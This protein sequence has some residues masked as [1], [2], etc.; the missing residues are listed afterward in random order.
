MV[1]PATGVTINTVADASVEDAIA[2]IDA[3]ARAAPT[4]ATTAP[5]H[6]AEILRRSF[7]LMMISAEDLAHLISWRTGRLWLTRAVRS[8]T[9][10]SSSAGTPRKLFAARAR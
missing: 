5:R 7:D 9:R 4:W 6:R 8:P 3:A 1:N 10:Q 2:A